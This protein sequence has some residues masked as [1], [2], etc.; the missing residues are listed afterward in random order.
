MIK[1]LI[2]GGGCFWCVEHDMREAQGVTKVVSGYS[3]GNTTDPTY[4]NHSGHR[5]VVLVEYDDAK[6]SYKK[7]LQHFID[8]IHKVAIS[9]AV[10]NT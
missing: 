6:T 10:G 9:V 5:E 8:H 2:L 1:S 4:E 3:G 7:L